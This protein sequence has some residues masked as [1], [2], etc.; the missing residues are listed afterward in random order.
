M[1]RSEEAAACARSAMRHPTA[2][3]VWPA[4]HLAATLGQ[5]A[6][7]DEVLVPLEQLRAKRQHLTVSDFQSWPHNQ[8]RSAEA[9]DH[10]CAGLRKAGVPE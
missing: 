1:N 4:I 2:D 9:L 10:I 6:R 5:L 3:S 8:T 7:S